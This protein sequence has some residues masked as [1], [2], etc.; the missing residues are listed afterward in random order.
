[1]ATDRPRSSDA[2]VAPSGFGA[3]AI[4]AQR[5]QQFLG[6]VACSCCFGLAKF[7]NQACPNPAERGP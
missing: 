2:V 1:M 6:R 3:L 7:V 5:P 4:P